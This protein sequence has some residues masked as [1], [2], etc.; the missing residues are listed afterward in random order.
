MGDFDRNQNVVQLTRG[1]QHELKIRYVE[2]VAD[3]LSR[4]RVGE[5]ALCGYWQVHH[6]QHVHGDGHRHDY[7]CV[8]IQL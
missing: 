8:C 7:E 3:C 1:E 4:F 5:A 6:D 2:K